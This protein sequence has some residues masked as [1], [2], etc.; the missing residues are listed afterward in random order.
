MLNVEVIYVPAGQKAIHVRCVF[1][2][3][4][5][6][7]EVLE[8]SGLRVSNPEITGLSVGIFANTVAL[9]TRVKPGDRIEIYRPLL[10]DPKEKRRQRAR[11]I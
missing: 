5:T 3:G 7:G 9:D 1:V 8:T 10:I 6:V 11:S 2:P 4:M